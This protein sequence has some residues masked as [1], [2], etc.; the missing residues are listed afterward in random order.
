MTNRK[1]LNHPKF[2]VARLLFLSIL[3]SFSTPLTAGAQGLG[4]TGFLA[5][6][7]PGGA[8][9]AT[10]INDI[11]I[12]SLGLGGLLALLMIVLAGYRYMTASG[13]AQQ[14]ENAKDAFSSA[15]IGLIVLFVGF[16]LLYVV[17]PQLT[18]LQDFNIDS[19]LPYP[20]TF[21]GG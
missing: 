7:K 1:S 14:V 18:Q 17:N 5:S 6:C 4:D 8:G 3:F 9:L 21:G 10:C 11:Y 20:P 15:L 13:N 19:K 16:V 2:G 12:L